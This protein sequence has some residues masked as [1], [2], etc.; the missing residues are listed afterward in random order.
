[1]RERSDLRANSPI[2]LI[3]DDS[4]FTPDDLARE[5]AFDT[6]NILNIKTPR[7]GY[8]QSMAMLKSAKSSHKGVM[9]GSHA[10]SIT[11]TVRAAIFA[12]LDGV[13]H[14]SELSFFLKA[15]GDITTKSIDIVDGYINLDSLEDITVD[16]ALLSEYSV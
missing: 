9:V 11:G 4:T 12:G 1:L 15:E 2:P 3:A 10:G 16:E 14:P 13:N 5:L 8:T 6:F 7:T